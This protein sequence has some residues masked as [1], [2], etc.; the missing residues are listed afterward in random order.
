MS[1]CHA[2]SYIKIVGPANWPGYGARILGPVITRSRI[3]M[4]LEGDVADQS[5]ES[6]DSSAT[7]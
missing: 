1:S 5:S 7:G 3:A 2:P 6:S 4:L